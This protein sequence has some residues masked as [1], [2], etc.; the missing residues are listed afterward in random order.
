MRELSLSHRYFHF[1][2]LVV[3]A[4]DTRLIIDDCCW[5]EMTRHKRKRD[6]RLNSITLHQFQKQRLCCKRMLSKWETFRHYKVER[7]KFDSQLSL[8]AECLKVCF[9][10][11]SKWV[12][13][14]RVDR[15]TRHKWLSPSLI[16]LFESSRKR[17]SW[18]VR[19]NEWNCLLTKET[20]EE[21]IK[22]QCWMLKLL[23]ERQMIAA[24]NRI[25]INFASVELA[26]F[27]RFSTS[28]RERILIN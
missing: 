15:L 28:E 11:I 17:R 19:G 13:V 2:S 1:I 22:R 3:Y 6:W 16:K 8:H 9:F 18:F 12:F 25:V 5:V 24:D 23:N 4:V 14:R 20:L 27:Q 26:Q 21:R 7:K 10:C